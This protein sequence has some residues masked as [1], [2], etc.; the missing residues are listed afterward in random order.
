MYDYKIKRSYYGCEWDKISSHIANYHDDYEEDD[1]ENIIVH[2][3][4][5][6]E[7]Y[8]LDDFLRKL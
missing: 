8:D 5:E 3:K 1:D 6:S 2:C 7:Y 4:S